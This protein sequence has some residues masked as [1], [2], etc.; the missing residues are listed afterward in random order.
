M[1]D[2]ASPN[3]PSRD[4]D[5]TEAFYVQLG[6]TRLYRDDTWMILERKSEH[7]R[8]VLEF[9]PHPELDPAESWFSACMRFTDL[10]AFCSAIEA[11]GIPQIAKGGPFYRPPKPEPG[12]L[13][14]GYLSDPDGSLIRL[15][16]S[17][18]VL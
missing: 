14:I 11:A 13:T 15:I 5:N 8:H 16:K 3:L 2:F 9:F 17:D 6:F 10:T 7:G 12:G 1:P 4:Y 18:E